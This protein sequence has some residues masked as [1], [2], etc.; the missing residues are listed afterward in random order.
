MKYKNELYEI[1][2]KEYENKFD[3]YGNEDVDEKEKYINEKLSN[4]RLHKLI[5]QIKVIHLLWDFD[6][7]SLY[8][9][10][11]WDEK[12]IYPRIET[13]YVFTRDMNDELVEKF[14]SGNFNQ[15]SAILKIKYYNPKNLIVQHLPI[16]ERVSKK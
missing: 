9:N 16:K 6:A 15:G 5:Q 12:S 14:N 7:V 1:F 8:P 4:L 2:E 11:M 13:G 3:D 10:A